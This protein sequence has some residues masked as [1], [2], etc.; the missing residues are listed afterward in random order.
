P[1]STACTIASG[2]RASGGATC[3]ARVA[4]LTSPAPVRR[5]ACAHS[6][7]APPLPASP[8]THSTWPW[9]PLWLSFARGRSQRARSPGSRMSLGC[10]CIARFY[11]CRMQ[12][13]AFDQAA[14]EA[15]AQRLKALAREAG[16]QRAGISDVVLGEDEA[17][18]R[19]WLAQG[20]H[21]SMHWMAQHG[22]K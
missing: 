7:I 21:G 1:E 16:F 5:A 2:W 11:T 20:L 6:M 8:P 22:D 14:L 18:L 15:L 19:D 17:H 13:P 12:A 9:S 3:A 4:T 10:G